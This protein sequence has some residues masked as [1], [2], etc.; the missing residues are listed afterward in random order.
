M[1]QLDPDQLISVVALVAA[2]GFFWNIKSDIRNGRTEAANDRRRFG[3]G[4]KSLKRRVMLIEEQFGKD[5]FLRK[6]DVDRLLTD[7]VNRSNR[8][9]QR[10]ESAERTIESALAEVRRE[11]EQVKVTVA[12]ELGR[13]QGATE[14]EETFKSLIDELRAG[15]PGPRGR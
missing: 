13:R 12:A 6:A 9:D 10:I 1:M 11:L 4:I 14:F 3:G 15:K 8:T 7:S 5:G 2:T